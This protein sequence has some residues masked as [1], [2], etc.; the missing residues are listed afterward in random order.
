MTDRPLIEE[1]F[2]NVQDNPNLPSKIP[3]ILI[4]FFPLGF[5]NTSFFCLFFPS[6]TSFSDPLFIFPVI[7]VGVKATDLR[8]QYKKLQQKTG[9]QKKKLELRQ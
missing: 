8:A 5:T 9:D 4:F 2:P 6:L 3:S 7:S 1:P